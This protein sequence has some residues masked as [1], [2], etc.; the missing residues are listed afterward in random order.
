ME[1]GFEEGSDTNPEGRDSLNMMDTVPFFTTISQ[2]SACITLKTKYYRL[3]RD[4]N[5]VKHLT[6]WPDHEPG[7][8]KRTVVL[9]RC[10][11]LDCK[12][13]GLAH[14]H[15]VI[16]QRVMAAEYP[17]LSMMSVKPPTQEESRK[18]VKSRY[19]LDALEEEGIL[20]M[21]TDEHIEEIRKLFKMEDDEPSLAQRNASKFTEDHVYGTDTESSEEGEYLAQEPDLPDPGV[22]R[23]F[24]IVITTKDSITMVINY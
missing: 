2:N 10:V 17:S 24:V 22:D 21:T 19:F 16:G 5:G 6:F 20:G 12:E 4:E 14:S 7:S 15:D 3:K 13:G 18:K 1:V 9:R 23:K 11:D 8:Q